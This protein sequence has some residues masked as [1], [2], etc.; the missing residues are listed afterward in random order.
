M[1]IKLEGSATVWFETEVEINPEEFE[2]WFGSSL[3]DADG[4]DIGEFLAS[5]RKPMTNYIPTMVP[6]YDAEEIDFYRR[7]V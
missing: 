5:G 3:D 4:M 6:T 7:I 2:E 1:K